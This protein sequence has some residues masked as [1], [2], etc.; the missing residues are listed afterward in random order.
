MKT[1]QELHAGGF[2]PSGTARY[3][4][5]A[6]DYCDELFDRAVALAE[7]DKAPNLPRE[8]THEHVRNAA[9]A[10]SARPSTRV[11]NWAIACQIGEYLCVAA[12]GVGGGKYE[13]SGFLILFILSVAFGIILFVS[14]TMRSNGS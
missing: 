6:N 5:T 8:V 9:V 3:N 1:P 11:S 7:A 13:Q 14:R 10:L 2:T 4:G 12:A